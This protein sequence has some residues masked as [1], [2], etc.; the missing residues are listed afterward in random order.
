M[1]LSVLSDDNSYFRLPRNYHYCN[2]CARDVGCGQCPMIWAKPL[3][4]IVNNNK[5]R[6]CQNLPLSRGYF[7][8]DMSEIIVDVANPVH[9]KDSDKDD[10]RKLTKIKIYMSLISNKASFSLF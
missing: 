3:I 4:D 1:S 10:D 7:D 2:D 9:L 6:C 8:H 5:A